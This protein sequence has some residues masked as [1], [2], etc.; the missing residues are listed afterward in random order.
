MVTWQADFYK[1]P[2]KSEQGETLWELIICDETGEIVL[3]TYC[4]QSQATVEWLQCQL[5]LLPK[6]SH[7]PEAIAVFRPE[8]LSLWQTTAQTLDLTIIPT[9]KTPVLKAL[10]RQRCQDYPG[11][12]GSYDPCKVELEPPQALPENLWGEN[13]RLGRIFAGDLWEM[14]QDQPIPY[15]HLPPSLEP[16]SYGLSSDT[17]IPG[18][19]IYGGRQARP[20]CQW[21][22][23]RH[24]LAFN[25]VV[26][27]LGQAG[28][29]VL[30][31]GLNER[32]VLVT[33]DNQTVAQGSQNFQTQKHQS[34]GLHF[35]L[36]Q[37]DDSGITTTGFW[38]FED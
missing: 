16:L 13:W 19:I 35:L 34:R 2:F 27:E 17:P 8:S 31:A 12:N 23:D 15:L 26:T 5:E 22:G 1:R 36:V 3:E 38:L 6:L 18:I 30:E 10:L 29:M 9:R 37:P 21:L 4:P 33:F 14:F 32:W 28:G 11:L 25:Y 7:P 20:L 24:P